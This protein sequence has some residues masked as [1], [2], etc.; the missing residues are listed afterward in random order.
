MEQSPSWDLAS[1]RSRNSPHFM[2]PQRFITAF[3]AA[4]H[5]SLSWAS[6]IQS[7]PPHL[8]LAID[9]VVKRCSITRVCWEHWGPWRS[10]ASCLRGTDLRP[11]EQW[12]HAVRFAVTNSSI[13][14][15]TVFG[16]VLSSYE[17]GASGRSTW[18]ESFRLFTITCPRQM[19]VFSCKC[20]VVS[21]TQLCDVYT[22]NVTNNA[23]GVLVGKLVRNGSLGWP[24]R[25][26]EGIKIDVREGGWAT[27][28]CSDLT[29]D[30]DNVG[31]LRTP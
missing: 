14:Q 30:T 8:I 6:S 13:Q 1:S 31:L 27:V 22:H 25:R 15:P 9:S 7:M 11:K 12:R 26:W 3:T 20:C 23:C 4:R 24:W 2:E 10:K 18:V 29:R 19:F 17:R 21:T 16:S 28:D 5:E